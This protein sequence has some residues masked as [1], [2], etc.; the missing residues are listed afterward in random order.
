MKSSKFNLIL[1]LSFLFV[2]TFCGQKHPTIVI[3]TEFGEIKVEIYEKQAPIAATNFLKYV[4]ENRF[5][6]GRFHRTVTM[7]NQPNND[8]KI[9]VI[10]GGLGN[11]ENRL[12]AIEHETTETTG[13]LHK[14]GTISMARSKPGSASSD[15]FICINDQP[16]LDFGGK[17]NPDGQG[18]S[19]FG[20]V[21]EG[22]DV[23]HK[24]HKQPV[25]GQSLKPAIEI[26]NIIR[27][28]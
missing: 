5:E 18:F 26:K 24:I 28:K 12:P 6:N 3:Q 10:Q 16:E 4:D 9:E 15:F 11:S 1:V 27:S 14:N 13:I 22:M 25:E 8:V 19:T 23:V 2:F 7:D 21:I 17:R 20:K